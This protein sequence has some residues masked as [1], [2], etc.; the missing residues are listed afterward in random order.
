MSQIVASAHKVL[1][2]A[3]TKAAVSAKLTK[4]TLRIPYKELL[5]SIGKE[6]T[7]DIDLILTIDMAWD[8]TAELQ[9][10]ILED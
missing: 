1:E 3:L 5:I 7:K 8:E 6:T 9:E 2:F 10:E 4:T